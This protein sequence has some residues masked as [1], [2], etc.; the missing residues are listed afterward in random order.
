VR[1]THA[2]LF[3]ATAGADPKEKLDRHDVFLAAM[4]H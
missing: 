1:Y 2:R 4:S 3:A